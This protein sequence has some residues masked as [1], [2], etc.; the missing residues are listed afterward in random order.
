MAVGEVLNCRKV[1]KHFV[2]EI[3]ETTFT[4]RRNAGSISA[5]AAPDGVSVIRTSVPKQEMTAG[6]CVRG[7]KFLTRV[8][9]AFR[10]IKTG[11]PRV[12]PIH[13]R[14]EH[15]VRAHIFLC[16]LAWLVEWHMRAA[17][18]PLLFPDPDLEESWKTRDPVEPARRSRA[19]DRKALTRRLDDGTAVHS[20][21]TLRDGLDTIVASTFSIGADPCAA[22]SLTTSP[23]AR[24][25]RALDLLREIATM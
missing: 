1:R 23:D 19:A 16:M 6:D 10:T 11:N 7:Y 24:Q 20:F 2:L 17:W 25:Q 22:I 14:L 8:E 9:R 4:F 18:T 13:H 21:R 15:R 3:T 5:E 12:R